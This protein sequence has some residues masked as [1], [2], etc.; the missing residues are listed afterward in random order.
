MSVDRAV[1]LPPTLECTD[2]VVLDTSNI[3]IA[4]DIEPAIDLRCSSH[5]IERWVPL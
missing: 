3:C 1:F 4:Q 5:V 2:T